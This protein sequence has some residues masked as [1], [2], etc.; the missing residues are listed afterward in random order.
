MIELYV[1]L[2]ELVSYIWTFAALVYCVNSGIKT[3]LF[4]LDKKLDKLKWK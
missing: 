1:K 3:Y 4:F 2:P